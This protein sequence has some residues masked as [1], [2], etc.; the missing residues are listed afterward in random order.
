[1]VRLLEYRNIARMGIYRDAIARGIAQGTPPDIV[2]ED[3]DGR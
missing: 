3:K 2:A 1:V